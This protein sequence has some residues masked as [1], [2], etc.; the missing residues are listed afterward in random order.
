MCSANR[1]GAVV[2]GGDFQGLGIIQNLAVN[3][4]AIFLLEHEWCIGRY[5]R[6]VKRRK[7]LPNFQKEDTFIPSLLELG[8]KEK[9]H[10]LV[11]FPNRIMMKR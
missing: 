4:V 11:L 5:S 7:Y 3:N 8:E 2:L 9:L 10:G 1:V 6:Y